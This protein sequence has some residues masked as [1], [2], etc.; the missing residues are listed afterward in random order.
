MSKRSFQA[1]HDSSGLRE[2]NTPQRMPT[3]QIAKETAQELNAEE[4]LS[5]KT[6]QEKRTF[7]RTPDGVGEFQ[8]LSDTPNLVNWNLFRDR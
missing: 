4:F 7:G 5:N 1:G 8:Q 3:S 2:R 6:S